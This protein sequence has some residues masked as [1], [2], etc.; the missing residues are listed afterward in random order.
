M[1]SRPTGRPY[2]FPIVGVFLVPS[3]ALALECWGS[4]YVN[5]RTSVLSQACTPSLTKTWDLSC[6]N[7]CGYETGRWTDTL[8]GHGDCYKPTFC[9]SSIK[10]LPVS[11]SEQQGSNPPSLKATIINRKGYISVPFPCTLA[12]RDDGLE[13]L[14]TECD[15]GESPRE[16]AQN[17]P[18][19]LSFEDRDV[20]LTSLAGGVRFDLDS[21]GVAEQVP[22]TRES[23]DDGFLVLDRD[24]DGRIRDGRELFGDLTP[25]HPTSRGRNGFEALRVLD[26]QLNGGNED[27]LLDDQDL[28]FGQIRLRVDADHDGDSAGELRSLEEVG[29][30]GLELD[31]HTTQRID[32]HGNVLRH[33]ARVFRREEGPILAWDVFLEA[34]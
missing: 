33:F 29:I 19:I 9:S 26:D 23:S 1:V 4:L 28:L 12:C 24:G 17:D 2:L 5:R 3:A 21:D 18:I 27:G 7:A 25:Q 15:C 10:C 14:Y 8:V 32:E 34:E 22:W 31:Y 13:T 30:V 20:A 11:G 6:Y 16:C